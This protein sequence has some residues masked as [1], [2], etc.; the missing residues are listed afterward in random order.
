MVM[1]HPLCKD[2]KPA[3]G[4]S[5]YLLAVKAYSND[6]EFFEVPEPVKRYV[7]QLEA[8]IR[9]QSFVGICNRYPE[10]FDRLRQTLCA[11]IE[12][13]EVAYKAKEN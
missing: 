3:P 9:H 11:G 6:Y 4:G 1:Y 12:G 10:R 2:C 5:H 13:A 8:A 7:R